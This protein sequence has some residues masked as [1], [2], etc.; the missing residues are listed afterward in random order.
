MSVLYFENNKIRDKVY[1]E[2]LQKNQSKKN[3]CFIVLNLCVGALY[4][5]S[6]SCL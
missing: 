2:L 5:S 4:L 3:L 1:Y 6:N